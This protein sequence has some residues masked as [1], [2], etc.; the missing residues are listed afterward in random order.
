MYSQSVEDYL[1]TIYNIIQKK[2]FARTKDISRNLGV[3]PPSVTEMMKKLDK[4]GLV[5]YER[6]GG[7]TLT[8]KGRKIAKIVKTRHNTIKEFLNVLL[9]SDKTADRD[10][11]ELEHVLSPETI[12][13]LTKFVKFVDKAPKYPKWLEHFKEFC[14]TGDFTCDQ[15]EKI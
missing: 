11:C 6:Y 14:K 13:Q 9:I 5:N 8:E 1:E 10:A 7:V 15:Q 3:T 2:G 12:E 4:D